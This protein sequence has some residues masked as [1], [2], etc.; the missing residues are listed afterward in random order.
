MLVDGLHS[1][2]SSISRESKL[3]VTIY[4]FFL[5]LFFLTL[6][7]AA[8]AGGIALDGCWAGRGLARSFSVG[9]SI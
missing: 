3:V 8:A 6:P 1:I 7:A 9:G 4:F 5:G 2:P